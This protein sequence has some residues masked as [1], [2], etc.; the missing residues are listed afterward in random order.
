MRT[1]VAIAGI[2]L[3]IIAGEAVAA[4]IPAPSRIESVTVF[5][6]GAETTRAA[7]L[8]LDKGE[9]TLVFSDLPAEAVPGSIRVDGKATAGL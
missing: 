1:L 4:E 3:A 7:R 9:H 5:P 6:S 8:S 2:S